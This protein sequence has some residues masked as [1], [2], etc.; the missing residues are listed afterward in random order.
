M[1]G[2]QG[3][4]PQNALGAHMNVQFD[5]QQVELYFSCR[6]LINLDAMSKSDPVIKVYELN[7]KNNSWYLKDQTETI[8]DNLNPDFAKSINV[9]YIFEQTQKMK[10]E[11]L[12]IDGPNKSDYIGAAEFELGELM[13]SKNNM[14]IID[15]KDPNRK[16]KSGKVIIRSEA[17]EE[18]QDR[19]NMRMN[20][21]NLDFNNL[22]S[23]PGESFLVIYKDKS[24]VN[25][26]DNMLSNDF[27]SM[28]K[29]HQTETY[30]KGK[31]PAFRN[32]WINSSKLCNSNYDMPLLVNVMRYKSN[33]DHKLKGQAVITVNKALRNE[34]VPFTNKKRGKTCGYQNMVVIKKDPLYTFYDYLKGG[35]NISA[36]VCIDFTGSNGDP[37]DPT[38]LHYYN[39]SQMN[40]YQQA[41]FSICQILMNY[42]SDKLV[43]TYG[44]GGAPFY[45][46]PGLNTGGQVCHF[47]PCSGQWDQTEAYGVDG[48]FQQYNTCIQYVRLSGPTYFAPLLAQ[49][50]D[51]TR[52]AYA[53]DVWNYTVLLIITD[54]AIHDF[55][56]SRDVIIDMTN[57]PI[58]VIIVGVGTANFGKMDELD[59]DDKALRSSSGAVA[60]RDI[61]QFV[62]FEKF[63]HDPALLAKEVLHELPNQ[64][65]E[66]YQAI[67]QPPKKAAQVHLSKIDVDKQYARTGEI[68]DAN[69][70]NQ[71]PD[72]LKNQFLAALNNDPSLQAQMNPQ[73]QA[74]QQEKMQTAY[75]YMGNI[76][77]NQQNP[78]TNTVSQNQNYPAPP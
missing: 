61:V 21:T 46:P 17:V 50:R 22:F 63:K 27:S 4:N 68:I 7:P 29:V 42:D 47:F 44:F 38:S 54:G 10:V 72:Q 28:I 56:P 30:P 35:Q 65:V 66:F 39:P 49:V 67:E 57:Q 5:R 69:Y 74:N 75:G 31:N 77:N 11:V 59:S 78:N 12:D 20:C 53:Q 23:S 60:L 58:S 71:H 2:N 3:F 25:N 6:K 48:I 18:K 32:F 76:M 14:L 51:F 43:P 55:G 64:V 62:P 26:A 40:S 41:I 73:I 24:G 34:Q 36:V 45:P 37:K 16:Q 33:G 9:D 8:Q 52:T 1:I 19:L 13:G 15:L 70:L